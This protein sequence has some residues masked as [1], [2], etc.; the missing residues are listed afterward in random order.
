MTTGRLCGQ[1]DAYL[2]LRRALG[3]AMCPDERLLR[4]FIAFLD[5]RGVD[6]PV[7]A[8]AALEWATA[9][10]CGPGYQ[11]RRLTIARGFLTYVRAVDPRVDVPGPGLLGRARRS[12]PHIY[13]PVE[14]ASLLDAARTLGPRGSLR[15]HTMATLIGVL[16]SCGLRAGEALRLRRTDVELDAPPPRLLIRQTKFRK[17][18]I[19]PV[20]ATTA[21]AL[22]DYATQR[23]ALGYD[24]LCDAFFVSERGGPLN[25][26]VTGATFV[27]LARRL[28]LRGPVGVRG[29]SLHQF[30]HTFAVERLA[31]WSRAGADVRARLPVL[32]VYL[33]HTR[34]QNT[35]WYLTA[36]PPLLESAAA[37]FDAYASGGG[38]P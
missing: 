10:S 33:G 30:R 18:R 16:A 15:P 20:H 13:T 37:R 2:A 21:D 35:Y 7:R 34:P 1:L 31:A 11:A 3:F 24:G 12:V 29:A 17:S 6:G 19:V 38:T 14:V 26:H 28:G 5:R 25:Y 22:R 8:Q 4:D 36:I 32:A 23:Q 27:A 9:V